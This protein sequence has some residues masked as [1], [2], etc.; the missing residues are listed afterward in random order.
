MT[1]ADQSG[2]LGFM[3]RKLVETKQRWANEGRLL[4]DPAA[5]P[6]TEKG[7]VPRPRLPRGQHE[8]KNWPVLDLGVT[9]DI[10]RAD[11][12]LTVDGLVE[13][14]FRWSWGD[15][16]AEP[17]T[18]DISDMH[19]VTAWSRFDN[20]WKG[21]AARHVMAI[22]GPLPEARFVVL[23]SYD[24]YT[25]NLPLDEFLGADVLLAHEW[26][27]KPITRDH[28]GPVRALIPKLYLWKSAKWLKRIELTAENRSGFWEVRGYHDYGDPWLEQRYG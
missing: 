6:H 8:V 26:E 11:W 13:R 2:L 28:G 5:V 9:P 22:A 19:C 7:T 24:G 20:H 4:T 15:L 25:T 18:V 3:R 1:D 10:A 21:V 27:G 12:T 14:D 17:Q 16:M 23:H